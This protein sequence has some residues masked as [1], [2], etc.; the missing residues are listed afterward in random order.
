M[1]IADQLEVDTGTDHTRAVTPQTLAS[2]LS[3]YLLSA[4]YNAADVLAKLLTVDGAGSG[5][6]A[7]VWQGLTPAQLIANNGLL[8]FVPVTGANGELGQLLFTSSSSSFGWTTVDSFIMETGNAKYA[9]LQVDA[10]V[11]ATVAGSTRTRAVYVSARGGNPGGTSFY[12]NQRPIVYV[13]S[14]FWGGG[15]PESHGQNT[16]IVPVN[17]LGQFDFAIDAP[18]SPTGNASMVL[19]GY[20]K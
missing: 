19:L 17:S 12:V 3:M 5:L 18:F 20:F 15:A 6:D 7:D 13:H 16:C 11:D 8:S 10:Y 14:K 4:G 9:V 2:I 1:E